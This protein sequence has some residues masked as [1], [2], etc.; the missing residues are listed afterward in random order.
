MNSSCT[1]AVLSRLS[2]SSA[3][4]ELSRKV[5]HFVC[6]VADQTFE[7]SASLIA[8]VTGPRTLTSKFELLAIKKSTIVFSLTGTTSRFSLCSRFVVTKYRRRFSVH[9]RSLIQRTSYIFYHHQCSCTVLEC[10][11]AS[12]MTMAVP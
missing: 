9:G 2:R 3:Q 6:S 8:T 5:L 10:K 1:T 11:R 7:K 4:M 12:K